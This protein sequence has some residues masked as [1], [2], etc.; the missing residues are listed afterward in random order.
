LQEVKTCFSPFLDN[1]LRVASTRVR[2]VEAF[3]TSMEGYV[4]WSQLSA[5]AS[6]QNL[7]VLTGSSFGFGYLS[8]I[9]SVISCN[10]MIVASSKIQIGHSNTG[11]FILYIFLHI[12]ESKAQNR[13]LVYGGE[14]FLEHHPRQVAIDIRLPLSV[15]Q[16]SPQLRF[17][18]RSFIYL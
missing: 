10:A 9:H 17:Q 4:G 3:Q 8:L 7:K 14:R 18:I 2:G 15:I 5:E 1:S 6:K 11:Y 16:N 12:L 13:P